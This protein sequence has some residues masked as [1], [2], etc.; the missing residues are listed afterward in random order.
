MEEHGF[1]QYASANN[2]IMIYPQAKWSI[3]NTKLCFNGD[4]DLNLKW[5][6]V[7]M[8]IGLKW[9]ELVAPATKDDVQIR[10]FMKMF[11]RVS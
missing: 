11:E 4:A 8:G 5:P 2:I 9:A 3:I 6:Y 7:W 1:T 10:A